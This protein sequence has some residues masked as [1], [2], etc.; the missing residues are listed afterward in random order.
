MFNRSKL[1]KIY[2]TEVCVKCEVCDVIKSVSRILHHSHPYF[3]YEVIMKYI[4][5]EY[6]VV[7][8]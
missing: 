5:E 2:Q 1:K 6:D 4:W 8:K 7:M 3:I